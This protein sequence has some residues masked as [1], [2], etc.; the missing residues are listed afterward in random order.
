MIRFSKK[1]YVQMFNILDEYLKDKVHGTDLTI[2]EAVNARYNGKSFSFEEHLKGFIYAQ[3][4]ALVSWKKIK[5]NQPRLNE[6]F[7][8]FDCQKLKEKSA[9]ELINEITALHC[10]NPYTTKNQ[11]HSLKA[12]IETFEK[13]EQEYES[14]ENF[15]MH[16]TP[17]NIIKLLADSKSTYKLKHAG[18]ALVCE[19][20]RNVGMDIIKPDV[21][22]KRIASAE[23]LNIT[24]TKNDYKIIDE[25]QELA[26]Q[27]GISQVKMDYLLWNYCAK[28]YGEI[29]TKTPKCEKCVISEFCL[30]NNKSINN[31]QAVKKTFVL[32]KTTKIEKRDNIVNDFYKMD[33]SS[34]R[35]YS[36]YIA[37]EK[38]H[39]IGYKFININSGKERSLFRI[40]N[41]NENT[42]TRFMFYRFNPKVTN[43]Y[44]WILKKNFND[45]DYGYL[46]FVIYV[47]NSVHV[48]LIPAKDVIKKFESRDYEGK[49]SAPEWGINLNYKIINFLISHYEIK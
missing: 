14:L 31:K 22:I 48:L 38:L 17:S 29:C 35:N 20:L 16:S 19:Y 5:D 18:V 7:C 41:N 33:K 46:V 39:N 49:K 3:L 12:N 8:N 47:V 26:K 34:I 15:I 28:G 2:L 43:N 40:T 9:E 24:T 45:K 21:H 25:F 30:K 13:I 32:K 37:T 1:D 36:E 4:S 6:I 27:I 44:A 11:M 23:R 42:L 10:H